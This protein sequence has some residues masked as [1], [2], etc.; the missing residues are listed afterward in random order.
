MLKTFK[1]VE[2]PDQHWFW[3]SICMLEEEAQFWWESVRRNNFV[4]CEVEDLAW[5]EFVHVFG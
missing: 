3:L 2:A 1:A 5:E 4:G